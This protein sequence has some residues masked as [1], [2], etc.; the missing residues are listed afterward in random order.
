MCRDNARPSPGKRQ[1]RSSAIYN[2]GST[3]WHCC[4][5]SYNWLFAKPQHPVP[6]ATSPGESNMEFSVIS[7]TTFTC[8]Q[9]F[10][11]LSSSRLWPD[12]FTWQERQ[13][14]YI[15]VH[16]VAP[17]WGMHFNFIL[18][19]CPAFSYFIATDSIANSCATSPLTLWKTRANRWTHP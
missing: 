9:I 8:L 14:T 17:R 12:L 6:V 4:H 19:V 3:C 15:P 18:C 11:L 7:V 13:Y 10:L 2:N 5:V 1:K 16:Q